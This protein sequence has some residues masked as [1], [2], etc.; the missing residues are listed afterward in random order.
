VVS[1]RQF[2]NNAMNH[3]HGMQSEERFGLNTDPDADGFTNE[4]TVADLT[5][6]SMYQATLPVPGRVIVTSANP[7]GVEVISK[8]LADA[9]INFEAIPFAM[10]GVLR[11]PNG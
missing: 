2:T 3:H 11:I 1:I 8:I 10:L 5:A 9:G 7:F 4:L 6:I